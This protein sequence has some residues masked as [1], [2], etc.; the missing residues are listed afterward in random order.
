MDTIGAKVVLDG[1]KQFREALSQINAEL[2]LNKSALQLAAAEAKAS[3]GSL[4]ALRKSGATLSAAI[5]GQSSA[6][7]KLSQLLDASNQRFGENS[8][9]ST[10]AATALNEAKTR[11][12]EFSQAAADNSRKLQEA[13]NSAGSF[14]TKLK[15]IFSFVSGWNLVDKG[16][17]NV[18]SSIGG[19]VERYDTLARVPRVFEM[20]GY[21]A[22]LSQA[23]ISKLS[24]GIKGLPTALNEIVNSTKSIA[25]MTGDLGLATDTAIALNNA[26]LASGSTA[27]DASRGF[28]QYN[29]MLAN[30]TVD[31][32][33]WRT[34]QETMG[35]AL[36]ETAKEL[37]FVGDTALQDLYKA[38]QS[39][40]VSFR[41]FNAALVEMDGRAGG[42]AEMAKAAS[43]GIGTSF[44]NMGIAIQRGIASVIENLN[45]FGAVEKTINLAGTGL[46][47]M[48]KTV[49]FLTPAIIGL[50]AAFA[51]RRGFDYAV[52]AVK[53]YNVQ[54]KIAQQA[55]AVMTVEVQRQAIAEA[56]LADSV[57]KNTLA[58]TLRTA[59]LAKEITVDQAGNLVK[60]NGVML[61][62]SETASLYANAT[63]L[64]VKATAAGILTGQ[65]N[66]LTAASN[67]FKMAWSTNPIGLA[68]TGISLLLPL[69]T[70][71]GSKTEAVSA[72]QEKFN[73]VLREAQGI[74]QED[75]R[76]IAA[77][78][79]QYGVT[80]AEAEQLY[81][82]QKLNAQ[83]FED[84][85]ASAKKMGDTIYDTYQ[86]ARE[87]AEEY[88]KQFSSKGSMLVQDAEGRAQA[89]R[90]SNYKL[91]EN[92]KEY[93][94]KYYAG[95]SEAEKVAIARSIYDNREMLEQIKRMYYTVGPQ[96]G[97]A[98]ASGMAQGMRDG[99]GEVAA[100][101]R[102]V[103]RTAQS[104]IENEL[105]INS[106]SKVTQRDGKYVVQGF[107]LGMTEN[108]RL[109]I[110][111]AKE[112]AAATR[113][114]AN[115][116]VPATASASFAA[117]PI[118]GAGN[119]TYIDQ[120][121]A[122]FTVNGIRQL[123]EMWNWYQGQRI[124][125]RAAGA[126]VGG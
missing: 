109:A 52:S 74:T 51:A 61:S 125:G 124:R 65:I 118:A 72:E 111:A 25:V 47:G 112:L 101:A 93:I 7:G 32:R 78:A 92:L 28:V 120:R 95:A 113:N 2:K 20:M 96:L 56:L 123:D 8:R 67:A 114:A 99:Q 27:G 37:G 102:S 41:Q 50:T 43:A 11:A 100:A 14:S 22:E 82:A 29:Q 42:F 15:D 48:L 94:D 104:T 80:A 98:V 87:A 90:R 88:N 64:G 5:S 21:D 55:S 39:G 36:K 58:E 73:S 126:P 117:R 18:I 38:L 13:A 103:A 68:I 85:A 49:G 17:R 4:D 53:Q 10:R 44:T 1:E 119:T 24:E 34:L 54:A 97:G 91:Y 86:E 33:S 71:L 6:V 84:T 31:M 30:G 110:N 3:S 19:A 63:A 35:Y 26:F 81:N 116:V 70:M 106:P 46:E 23:S 89:V 69:I 62:N 45:R 121:T 16:I 77:L 115:F 122:N 40:Q 66:F 75:E 105:Q 59:A 79:K 60:A 107:A 9:Q 12:A 57:Q 83:G 108:I 76:A